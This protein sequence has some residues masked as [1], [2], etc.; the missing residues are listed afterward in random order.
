[1]VLLSSLKYTFWDQ[2]LKIYDLDQMELSV[3]TYTFFNY[4]KS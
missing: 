2:K 1:M 3:K 4:M